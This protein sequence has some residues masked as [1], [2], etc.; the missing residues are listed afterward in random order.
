[1]SNYRELQ[2]AKSLR[3]GTRAPV[4]SNVLAVLRLGLQSVTPGNQ[5]VCKD[6]CFL[7]NANQDKS[8][9]NPSL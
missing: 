1:M 5:Y 9:T 7:R 4:S 2:I 8:F 6:Y 3:I